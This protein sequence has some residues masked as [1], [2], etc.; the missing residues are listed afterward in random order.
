MS[1]NATPPRHTRPAD[2]TPSR[3]SRP[4]SALEDAARGPPEAALARLHASPEGL[5]RRQALAR[6]RSHGRNV[7]FDEKRG[8]SPA[9]LLELVA[10]PLSLL[11]LGLAAV[12]WATG[13]PRGALVIALIVVFNIIW[14]AFLIIVA[15][16][17]VW[18]WFW[19]LPPGLQ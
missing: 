11:L 7:A 13:E 9:R 6:L 4:G 2:A 14:W 18:D 15:L 8:T 17:I 5:T 16:P 1:P 10:S 3:A 19:Q 12:S